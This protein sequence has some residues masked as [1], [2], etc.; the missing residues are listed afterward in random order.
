M[1]R[2]YGNL[3]ARIG[4]A[5]KKASISSIITVSNSLRGSAL[6]GYFELPMPLVVGRLR[7]ITCVAVR[8]RKPV[9]AG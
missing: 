7:T 6:L 4:S 2:G 5:K 3:A 9:Q 8:V 1:G